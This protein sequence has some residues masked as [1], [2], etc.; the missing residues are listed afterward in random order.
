[1]DSSNA[2]IQKKT[3]YGRK[4]FLGTETYKFSLFFMANG[5]ENNAPPN[6]KSDAFWSVLPFGVFI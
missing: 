6:T 4:K 3:V 2:K 5:K 1:V